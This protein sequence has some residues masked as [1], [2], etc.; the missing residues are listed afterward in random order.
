MGTEY[1]ELQDANG[2][3]AGGNIPVYSYEVLGRSSNGAGCIGGGGGGP[4][5]L[6]DKGEMNAMK[7]LQMWTG[8]EKNALVAIRFTTFSN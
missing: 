5:H 7:T 2:G 4:F 1:G 3:C 8:G 6:H